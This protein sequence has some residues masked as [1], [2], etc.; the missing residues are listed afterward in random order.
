MNG[1]VQNREK[2]SHGRSNCNG[3][4]ILGTNHTPISSTLVQS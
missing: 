3:S 4:Y 1:S 2:S